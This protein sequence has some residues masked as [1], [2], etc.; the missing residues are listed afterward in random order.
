MPLTTRRRLILITRIVLIAGALLWMARIYMYSSEV[1]SLSDGRS[2]RTAL[3]ISAVIAEINH[4]TEEEEERFAND[5][6]GFIRK[7]AH[8]YLYAVL[9]ALL[10]GVFLTYAVKNARSAC[11][12]LLISILYAASDEIH[13]LFVPGRSGQFKD[14][15]IDTGGA[16]IGLCAALTV[17][18]VIKKI[19]SLLEKS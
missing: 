11:S 4:M 9:A 3:K 13:Q 17:Y 10:Y 18:F 16:V 19:K 1:A 12:S 6:E 5:I 15:I 2:S 14:V 7:C 8:M